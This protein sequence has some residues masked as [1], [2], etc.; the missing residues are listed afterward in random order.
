MSSQVNQQKR[1]LGLWSSTSTVVCTMIGAG[2]FTVTGLFAAEL[3][4]NVGILAVWAVAGVLALCGS[5][6]AIELASI[7]P[8]AGGN[9]IFI[10]NIFGRPVGF[11]AGFS[12][13]CFGITGSIA[14]VAGSFGSYMEELFPMVSVQI[15][16]TS[17]ILLV[18]AIHAIGVR[19]GN[20]LNV[21]GAFFKVSLLTSLIVFGFA[22]VSTAAPDAWH[23]YWDS[24]KQYGVLTQD[25]PIRS[26]GAE[27][28][29]F[30]TALAST[31]FAYQGNMATSFIGG[32]IRH[33]E[34]NL[35]RSMLFGI[36]V[37]TLL[38]L[39][40][41][42]VYLWAAAPHEMVL[43]DGKGIESIGIFAAKRLFGDS[44]AVAFNVLIMLV[45]FLALGVAVML[46]SRVIYAMARRGEL[47]K[48]MAHLNHRG[49]PVNALV[50]LCTLSLILIWST[51]LKELVESVGTLVTLT[52][53]VA[54][55]G[56][57]VLRIREPNLH[58]PARTPWFPLPPIV[59][60]LST[61]WMTWSVMSTSTTSVILIL[62]IIALALV[63]WFGVAKNHS[64]PIEKA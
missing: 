25:K 56:V 14:Y 19:E 53:G 48:Q 28:A 40:I 12:F 59:F 46:G 6:C 18:T 47:P 43:A 3:G 44:I 38:Y 29:V 58:R 50:L 64:R 60:L 45:F 37:V 34:K 21:F 13:A 32:E 30:G 17:A 10:R 35:K 2:I 22:T 5:L 36:S 42:G 52:T 61:A 23:G 49:S 4:S 26:L 8:E 39:I 57:V 11:V 63:V 9:Y 55:A 15:A 41:N 16:A 20:A 27:I 24:C 54:V 51:G 62:G 7:W 1:V 33:P 31:S